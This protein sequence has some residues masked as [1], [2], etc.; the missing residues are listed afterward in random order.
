MTFI[1]FDLE[2]VATFYK[3]QIPEIISIG[4]VKY[5]QEEGRLVKSGE[6]E[7]FV[8]PLKSRL[9]KRTIKITG[10]RPQDIHAEEIFPKVWK[11]FIK[12]I[13][14]EDYYLL[15]WGTE[16]VRTLIHNCRQHRMS[17]DWLR[18]YNDLQAEFGRLYEQKNQA[19]LMQALE[20]L[21]L[22]AVGQHHSAIDDARNTGEIFAACFGR[23]RLDKNHHGQI[24]KKYGPKKRSRVTQAPRVATATQHKKA[25]HRGHQRKQT[26]ES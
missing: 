6:F 9:N 23:L 12:W 17:L 11:R 16:D 21:N 1:I 18:N 5:Q 20:M 10:I 19:G 25:G 8:R 26:I 13:G 15:T 3:G 14:E 2:W 7:T 4:A 24:K 22:Q